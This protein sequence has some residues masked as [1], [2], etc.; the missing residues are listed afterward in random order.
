MAPDSVAVANTLP[1]SPDTTDGHLWP[2]LWTWP[3]GGVGGLGGWGGAAGVENAADDVAAMSP[4]RSC[5]SSVCCCS[6]RSYYCCC[7][8]R[9]VEM[10]HGVWP[11]GGAAR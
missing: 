1:L 10:L 5:P 7:C 6:G 8:Q 4:R 2:C 11:I 3:M 9:A